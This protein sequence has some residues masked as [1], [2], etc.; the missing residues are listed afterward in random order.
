MPTY[1]ILGATG[2]TG[3]S[4]LQL[5]LEAPKQ[6]EP[7]VLHLYVRSRS[8]LLRQSPSLSSRHDVQIFEG[9]MDDLSV[10]SACLA[11]TDVVFSCLAQNASVPGMHIA[12]EASSEVIRTLTHV[13]ANRQDFRSPHVVVLSAAPV[14]PILV[15][16]IPSF[17][18]WLV[19]RAFSHVYADLHIAEQMYRNEKDWLSVTFVQ[20]GGLTQGPMQGH[21]LHHGDGP[22][23]AF[24]SYLDLAGAMIEVARRGPSEEYDWVAISS[25]SGKALRP[26]LHIILPLVFKGLL[27]HFFPGLWHKA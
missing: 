26:K 7:V 11:Q 15:E 5:L 18:R 8:K 3:R 23:T 6:E 16:K 13:K 4:I 27:A 9:S 19:T 2:N 25:T 17:P 10:F 21:L 22:Q 12:Q 20:P 1:T 24:L 14:N